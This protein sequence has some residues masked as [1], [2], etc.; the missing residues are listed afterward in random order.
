[1]TTREGE[2]GIDYG[3]R[4]MPGSCHHRFAGSAVTSV[5]VN[6][7]EQQPAAQLGASDAAGAVT[8][9][10]TDV[11]GSTRLWETEP[12]RMRPAMARHDVIVR[13]TVDGHRGTVVKMTGDGIHAAFE[14]PLDALLAA[15]DIQLALT[16]ADTV[17]A[18][19]LAVRC[20]LHAG[21][22]ERRDK[23]FFGP[24]VNRAARIMSAAHGGQLLLSQE[25]AAR[26]ADALPAGVELRDLG[27]VRLRDLTTPERLYQVLHPQLRAQFPPLRSLASTP[28]NLPQQLN[29]F[30]GRERELAET[31]QKLAANRML[32]LLGMGGIGKSRLSLQLAAEVLDDF[33]DGVWFV[34][35]APLADERSVPQALASVLGVKEEAGRPVIEAVLKYVRDKRLLVVLDNCEHVVHACADLAKQL[36][37]A[38]AGVKVLTS[39][40]DYLQIAGETTYHVPTL[41]A[42]DPQKKE[43]LAA[44]AEHEAV[45]LFID[46][47]T[48]A[49]PEF[50]LTEKNAVAVTE[51]CHR[52]DGIP[53]ALELAAA[54]ARAL[55]VE[56]IAT[57]LNDRFKLLATGDR[58]VLPR[59]RTLRA[60]IDWSYELLDER[61]R[62]LFQRLAVFA[63]G[64]TL[65]A[66]E[67]VCA[68]GTIDG[69]GVLDLQTQLVEKSLVVMELGGE[70]YRMLDTVRAYAAEKLA[71]VPGNEANA[72]MQRHLSHYLAHAEQA[73]GAFGGPDQDIA[74]ARLDRDHENLLLAHRTAHGR[75]DGVEPGLR[76]IRALKFYWINRGLLLLGQEVMRDSLDRWVD[77]M[78]TLARCR[79]LFDLGQL[80]CFIGRYA[81]GAA[82]LESSLAIA[83][84]LGDR[85]RIA[86]VLQP[87]G[88]AAAAL[89]DLAAA[90]DYSAEAVT[91]ARELGNQRELASA[92]IAVAQLDRME[93]RLDD[94]R[95]LYQQALEIARELNDQEA[96]AIALVNL[97]MV[98]ITQNEVS[99]AC[100][101]LLEVLRIARQSGSRPAGQSA[102]DATAAWCAL[103]NQWAAAAQYYGVS[104]AQA[105]RSGSRRDAVDDAF[106]AP[107]MARV[108]ASIDEARYRDALS[109]GEQTPYEQAL[110]SALRLLDADA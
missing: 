24:A 6:I 8:F 26:V 40:R 9:M 34:E 49:R 88:M 52:L 47:V 51:I 55:S 60:L 17:G 82:H 83:R 77:Q 59:Q 16:A 5:P 81:E 72:V 69:A 61:E 98:A 110:E 80:N 89:G 63:G 31:R 53:L 90:R 66:A 12:E 107:F 71:A 32:T 68:G 28:N 37:Q 19:G 67:A 109:K 29:S 3:T 95:R 93:S 70:R 84:T 38:G 33:P 42:P 36:L 91:L 25:V 108:R 101:T 44:L 85:T 23:D 106:L 104:E 1:M 94:A 92:L 21:N 78:P 86:A 56:N 18:T 73:R 39:S 102:L 35:L 2:E 27:V 64:W 96:V 43:S 65:E 10:F 22:D 87:L 30:I 11:E 105:K 20:G 74:M 14:Q 54:R 76:L 62:V 103:R 58:T 79:A 75:A 100:N 50:A 45:R 41:S 57:R 97:A 46:R 13:A 99:P 4:R 48:A 15:L 7:L